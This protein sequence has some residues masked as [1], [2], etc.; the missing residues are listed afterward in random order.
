[1]RSAASLAAAAER[2]GLHLTSIEEVPTSGGGTELSAQM[3]FDDPWAAA[4]LLV[5]L[6]EEDA[7]DPVVR[8]WALD[9][10]DAA[11]G[12]IGE[13]SGPS[14]SPELRDAAARTI[15]ASVKDQIRFVH[16]PQETF[17]SA[18]VTI[19][20][21]AGD[22]DDHARLVY[23][24]ARVLNI[25]PELIFFEEQEQPIHVVARMQDSDGAWQWSETTID[26]D[27]GED[28]HAALDRLRATGADVGADPFSHVTGMSG[29]FGFV[30]PSDVQARKDQ[31]NAEVEATDVDVVNCT[32]LDSGTLSAWNLFLVAWRTFYGDE[33]G[34]F[35]AGAQGR[36]VAD[37]VDQL[38]EWQK[39]L[40]AAG[41]TL[42]AA[43]LPKQAQD[44]VSGTIKVVA[45]GAAVVAGAFALVEVVKLLP[46][47]RR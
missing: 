15:H 31:V 37:Y 46:R 27:Y 16:E 5:E 29:P 13:P 43:P 21:K 24:L 33:P 44:D 26:A 41:C 39:R 23:A 40:T 1:M 14:V 22:C 30:T 35:S 18:R 25:P 9:I 36:Q 12:A 47:A 10:L 8:A 28:P 11:A 20:S 19:E 4:R 32:K 17:Q 7:A 45:I 2:S 38:A 42:T 34:F 6:A 3:T